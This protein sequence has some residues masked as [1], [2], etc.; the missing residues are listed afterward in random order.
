MDDGNGDPPGME[1]GGEGVVSGV[2]AGVVGGGVFFE[3]VGSF[4]GDITGWHS[5][6]PC[7]VA[8]LGLGTD[9]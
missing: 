6:T 3:E 5:G 4:T 8:E 7:G 2:C 1:V 9:A